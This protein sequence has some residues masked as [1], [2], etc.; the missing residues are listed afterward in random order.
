[1]KRGTLHIIPSLI[2]EG[3]V[4]KSLPPFT[5]STIGALNEFVAEDEKSARRFIKTV[6]PSREIR[7]ITIN[8]LNEHTRDNE[9][10]ILLKPLLDGYDVGLISDAGA[11][12]VADPGARLV[13]LA[14]NNGISVIPHVG[15]SSILLALMG[16]GLEGQRFTF[17]GYLPAK[18]DERKKRI[19]EIE[20]DCLSQKATHI[21]IE[22]PYRNDAMLQDIISTC[23]RETK[24]CIAAEI[25][26]V[27]ESIVTKKIVEWKKNPPIL[28]DK[29]AVFLI[30]T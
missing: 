10:P 30:G 24:L 22:T 18:A 2:A 25:T 21:W 8:V 27:N 11:P 26:G 19:R 7:S 17:H 16:S 13:D 3:T 4:E 23:G 29:P 12:C 5:L 15:P 14:H 28:K 6:C 9:I 20:R 1:M